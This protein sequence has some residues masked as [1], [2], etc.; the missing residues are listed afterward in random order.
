MSLCNVLSTDTCVFEVPNENQG[1]WWQG[2]SCLSV[3]GLS[4][5]V[6]L[7]RRSVAD[8]HYKHTCPFC[9]LNPDTLTPKSH[10]SPGAAPSCPAGHWHQGNK[11][12]SPLPDLP[13]EPIPPIPCHLSHRSQPTFPLCQWLKSRGPACI[14]NSSS[15]FPWLCVH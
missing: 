9:A 7:V 6:F 8:P 12:S 13:K 15:L 11:T 10:P 4:C 5:M 1:L 3:K 2:H 14:S